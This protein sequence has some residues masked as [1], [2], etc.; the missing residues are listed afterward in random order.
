M[1]ERE[2]S[3]SVWPWVVWSIAVVAYL[4]GVY[5]MLQ[6]AP[7]S[8]EPQRLFVNAAEDLS[9]V[10]IASLALVV[11]RRQPGNRVGWW[12]MLAGLS[13]PL[14]EFFSGLAL[15]G[16]SEWGPVFVTRFAVWV[17]GW[18]WILS[19][20][21]LPFIFLYYPDG[22]LPSPRWRWAA[23]VIWIVA[24]ALFLGTAFG[25]YESV[26]F[27]MSNPGAIEFLEPIL[28]QLGVFFLMTPFLTLIGAV[29][30]IFRYRQADSVVR[31][32]VKYL[33]LAAVLA[34]VFF[35][36]S[37]VSDLGEMGEALL[38][39]GFT[40]FIGV[41]FT[42]G[43]V[44]YRLFDIDGL[45]SRTVSYSVLVALLGLVF[46]GLVTTATT[47]L[48]AQGSLAVAGSTLAVAALFNPVRI[49]V[50]GWVDRRFNRSRYDAER[51]IDAFGDSLRA[52]VD[53]I[54]LVDGWVGVVEET[55]QPTGVGVWVR[56]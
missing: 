42:A 19:Q 45:I 51:V 33:S 55:M 31:Q 53:Q 16:V 39:I 13:F 56:D 38:N 49:R 5:F 9:F 25:P 15:F 44:R 7:A 12:M 43:I 32:Q 26:E 34:V 50:Q 29:S 54:G 20:I 14:E 41:V 22:R 48:P 2:K 17:S 27:G 6:T 4:G 35:I 1:R 36:F 10:L 3:E 11:L 21:V 23:R 30:L 47:V 28:A 18:I 40:L 8:N 52:G 37:S 46:V 24:F